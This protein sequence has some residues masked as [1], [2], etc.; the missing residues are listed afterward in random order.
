MERPVSSRNLGRRVLFAFL[1][2]FA[3]QRLRADNDNVNESHLSSSSISV[4]ASG[5]GYP[6]VVL[7]DGYDL[8]STAGRASVLEA[9]ALTQPL[10]LTA[11]DFDGDGIADLVSG[12]ADPAGL[13]LLHRGNVDALFASPIEVEEHRLQGMVGDLPFLSPPR[14]FRL[15]EVPSFLTTGDFNG[16]GHLDVVAAARGSTGLYL[17]AGD[18]VGGLDEPQRVPLPGRVTALG[19]GE[20]NRRDGLADLAVAVQETDGSAVLVFQWPTG[21]LR[22]APEPI[23]L[24]AAATDLLLAQLDDDSFADIAIAA[25]TELL[26]VRGRDRQLTRMA[27]PP[28]TP[29]VPAIESRKLPVTIQSLAAGDFVGGPHAEIAVLGEDGAVRLLGTDEL[30]E[31]EASALAANPRSRHRSDKLTDWWEVAL[32]VVDTTAWGGSAAS[33]GRPRLVRTSVSSLPKDDLVL[34]DPTARQLRLIDQR[35]WLPL[36]PEVVAAETR[37]RM[38]AS[39]REDEAAAVF[40][41]DDVPIAVLPLR[42]NDDAL[43]DLVIL[44]DGAKPL[45]VSLTAAA[46]TFTVTSAE[47]VC[48]ADCLGGC[49]TDDRNTGDGRCEDLQGRCTLRAALQ[50]ANVI[51]GLSSITINVGA[52][53]IRVKCELSVWGNPLVIDGSGAGHAELDGSARAP[54]L[55]CFYPYLRLC[56]GLSIEV[57]KTTVRGLTINRFEGPGIELLGAGGNYIEGNYV[58]TDRSG[59]TAQGNDVGIDVLATSPENTIGGDSEAARN[60]ISGNGNGLVIRSDDNTVKGNYIGPDATGKQGLGARYGVLISRLTVP[61]ARRNVVL[62]NVISGNSKPSGDTGAGV[63]VSSSDTLIQGNLIGTDKDGK[64]RLGNDYGVVIAGPTVET[65]SDNTIGGT[66]PNLGNVIS[67]N[68]LDGVSFDTDYGQA[69]TNEVIGNFIGTDKSDLLDLGNGGAGVWVRGTANVVGGLPLEAANTIAFNAEAGVAAVYASRHAILG[70]RIHSNHQLGIDV[71][72][73]GVTRENVPVLSID[74]TGA[75]HVA[76]DST[77]NTRFTIEFFSNHTCDPSGYGEGERFLEERAVVTTDDRGHAEFAP[78]FPLPAGEFITATATSLASDD[79]LD[80]TFEFSACVQAG[81]GP[82][83][84]ATRTVTPTPPKPTPTLTGTI[85]HTTTPTKVPTI[86]PTPAPPVVTAIDVVQA[87][88]LAEHVTQWSAQGQPLQRVPLPA[89]K[90]LN[91][92]VAHKPTKV[93]VYVANPGKSVQ[94]VQVTLKRTQVGPPVALPPQTKPVQPQ[95]QT[96][97]LDR[98]N[99]GTIATYDFDLPPGWTQGTTNL[100]AELVPTAGGSN[101]VTTLNFQPRNLDVVYLFFD[102]LTSAADQDLARKADG[103]L[104]QLYPAVVVYHRYGGATNIPLTCLGGAKDFRPCHGRCSVTG[105]QPCSNSSECPPR[106][107]CTPI[108]HCSTTNAVACSFNWQCPTGET[109]ISDECSDAV[110]GRSGDD[111]YKK[112]ASLWQTLQPQ[113]EVLIGWGP[114][115]VVPPGAPPDFGGIQTRRKYSPAPPAP[116]VIFSAVSPYNVIP[117]RTIPGHASRLLVHETGHLFGLEHCRGCPGGVRNGQF[118]PSTN[119]EAPRYIET[120]ITEGFALRSRGA[121]QGVGRTDLEMMWQTGPDKFPGVVGTPPWVWELRNDTNIWLSQES[122]EWL[123]GRLP[124]TRAGKRVDAKGVGQTLT[125]EASTAALLLR[126]SIADGGTVVLDPALPVATGAALSDTG[127]YCLH[128]ENSVGQSLVTHCFNR[129]FP[130]DESEPADPSPFLETVPRPAALARVSLWQG[131]TRLAEQVVSPHVPTVD[132]VGPQ[133]GAT[134]QGTATVRWSG[135]DDDGDALV[136]LV[137]YSPDDRQSWISLAV[138][139]TASELAVDTD[140]IAGSDTGYLRVVASD[141]LNFGSDEVGPLHVPKKGP[142]VFIIAPEAGAAF[143][144]GSAVT[145]HATGDDAEDGGL[146]GE[147][148]EWSSDRDGSLGAGNRLTTTG[149]SLG[150]HHL[151]VLVKDSDGNIGTAA[152][153]IRIAPPCIGDCNGDR[154]VT[155]DE[156][157]TGVNI[158]LDRTGM[159]ECPLFDSNKDVRLTIDELVQGVNAALEGCPVVPIL[160]TPTP[161]IPTPTAT[162]SPSATATMSPAGTPT[163]TA[164]PP[165]TASPSRTPTAAPAPPVV[166]AFTCNGSALCVVQLEQPFTMQFSFS[167]VNGNANSWHLTAERDDGALFD[168]DQGPISPP[169]GSGIVSRTSLGFSCTGGSCVTTTWVIRV[170]ITDSTGLPSQPATVD[171]IVLG[172]FEMASP[173]T[174]SARPGR[175]GR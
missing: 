112:L 108:N 66:V 74:H 85:T 24:P 48:P 11:G 36:L 61:S 21:A 27:S 137:Q 161:T 171:V 62:N 117:I 3:A 19:S 73:D 71:N 81:T 16:D 89:D 103:L 47:D 175:A 84:T 20:I 166:T 121:P 173:A 78:Q 40:D 57:G 17:L 30:E 7:S 83:V 12:Y 107:V 65:A 133:P 15:P 106:E 31:G 127:E 70:N 118:N 68:L 140:N 105:S 39:A 63:R 157:V 9:D 154:Q 165:R 113:P 94:N 56:A 174:G 29:S 169:S 35:H 82:T 100:Q 152:V 131:S 125:L 67:A 34:I 163:A 59:A 45:A 151:T 77:P 119:H 86:T 155:V 158:A 164:T 101:P 130:T 98:E 128:L 135:R 69:A 104:D 41:V 96:G 53:P 114:P 8:P 75:L 14:Q 99:P 90:Q 10:A 25:G 55:S 52:S 28:A 132:V 44:K 124:S 159:G 38:P 120:A 6:W 142:Q 147:A 168:I 4:H 37:A 167:D 13:L 148:F 33:A 122:W 110:C 109:C 2:L 22:G 93:R 76:L 79:A 92:L 145:L 97:N 136:Y 43:S 23:R 87:I 156:L 72:N 91:L 18:G 5:R 1:L 170:V 144:A 150:L 115:A 58:G 46:A 149:L 138:D 123:F 102:D 139:V 153:D 49:E 146:T 162:P 42:L 51:K 160:P 80:D 32:P 26:I 54:G 111:R 129:L 95:P 126:G 172:S 141:G 88:G 143:P 116:G 64:N 134:W 60:V 50:E